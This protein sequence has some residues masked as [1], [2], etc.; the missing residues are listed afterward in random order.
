M[1]TVSASFNLND[2]LII[3]WEGITFKSI[4]FIILYS[5]VFNFNVNFVKIG[6]FEKNSK[7]NIKNVLLISVANVKDL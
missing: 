7:S 4:I 5:K 3:V 1:L 2:V 6:P